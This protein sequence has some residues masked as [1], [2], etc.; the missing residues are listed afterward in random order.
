M[1]VVQNIADKDGGGRTAIEE[2]YSSLRQKILMA[3]LAP[4]SRL[5][6]EELRQQYGVGSSTVR[7]A[8]SHLLVDN[9]VT[10]KE[11]RGFHVAA[12]S[13]EDFRQ[14]SDVRILL[15]TQ[16][17]RDSVTNGDD[18]WE[19]RVVAAAH[20]LAKVEAKMPEL[21][22]EEDYVVAWEA[23]NND[24]HN[25]LVSACTNDWLLRFR[26]QVFAHS[27]RYRRLSVKERN[28]PR[29]VRAEHQALFEAAIARDVERAVEVTIEHIRKS[30]TVL[31]AHMAELGKTG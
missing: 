30:V 14:I 25:A 15:E 27:F 22:R 3:E 26:A 20:Q 4:E 28:V 29:D 11:Q 21:R 18:E 23:R 7:E 8:L 17:V 19:N 31:E 1:T 9:L 24:F 12:V 2:V 5:R 13:Q 6:V 16:A 10:A